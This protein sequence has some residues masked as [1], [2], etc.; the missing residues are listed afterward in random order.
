MCNYLLKMYVNKQN[1]KK[2]VDT[3]SLSDVDF[4]LLKKK[5]NEN[6]S[7]DIK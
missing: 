5:L 4:F 1:R 2:T 7:L 3:Q 6:C